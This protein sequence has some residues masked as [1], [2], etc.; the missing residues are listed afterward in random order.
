MKQESGVIVSL[1][2]VS[3]LITVIQSYKFENTNW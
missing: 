3:K 1:V 2:E